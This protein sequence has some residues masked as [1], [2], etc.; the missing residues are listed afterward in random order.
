MTIQELQN[1]SSRGY[2]RNDDHEGPSTDEK[3]TVVAIQH[4]AMEL[5]E[6]LK[7]PERWTRDSIAAKTSSLILLSARLAGMHGLNLDEKIR[8]KIEEA[9]GESFIGSEKPANGES[10]IKDAKNVYGSKRKFPH[11]P[12]ISK[13]KG[14]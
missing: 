9:K 2:K 12:R 1:T 10:R 7:S 5:I 11:V 13:L 4:K 6:D 14:R 8:V 3:L